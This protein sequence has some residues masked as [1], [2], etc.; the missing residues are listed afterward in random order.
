MW[1]G[2]GTCRELQ[3]TD[4]HLPPGEQRSQ[5]RSVVRSR[6]L[7]Y[8]GPS[9][10]GRPCPGLPTATKK[11]ATPP[12]PPKKK[13]IYIRVS[14]K[15]ALSSSSAVSLLL[16]FCGA[17]WIRA[18][19]HGSSSSPPV[20]QAI[21][22]RLCRLSARLWRWLDKATAGHFTRTC[23]VKRAAANPDDTGRGGGGSFFQNKTRIRFCVWSTHDSCA[24][25]GEWKCGT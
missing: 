4:G 16:V 19:I 21:G 8:S 13:Y 5:V 9:L 18:V 2:G 12:T 11:T 20:F 24:R 3:P 25:D 14:V 1:R 15:G 7:R 23:R 17:S 6:R 22:P 10:L